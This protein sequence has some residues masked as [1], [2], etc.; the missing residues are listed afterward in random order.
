MAWGIALLL[1]VDL[2][3]VDVRTDVARIHLQDPFERL[4][5][6][7]GSP[8]QTRDETEDV[9]RPRIAR[10]QARR[11]GR[12]ALGARRIGR[13]EQGDAEVDAG[14]R[15]RR[16][17]PQRTAE[18]VGRGAV[19]ELLEERDP[20]VIRAI[21]VFARRHW[22]GIVCAA[23]RQAYACRYREVQN[24]GGHANRGGGQRKP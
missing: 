18:C 10:Q 9:W 16:I 7:V 8:L 24:G 12:F 1:K 14:E 23:Q 15:E 2:S 5:C 19:L 6:R 13:V 11:F 3:E 20:E 4:A 22:G 21:G 17:H